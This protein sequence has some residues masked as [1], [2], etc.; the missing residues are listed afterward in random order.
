MP[1]RSSP[2]AKSGPPGNTAKIIM[3]QT[4]RLVTL[5]DDMGTLRPG[6]D[7]LQVSFLLICAEHVA[8]LADRFSGEGRSREYTKQFFNRFASHE[9]RALI[10]TGFWDLEQ[11]PLSLDAAIDALYDIRCD[12][13]HEGNYWSFSF[14]TGRYG[15]LSGEYDLIAQISLRDFRG[16]I[17]RSGI[18]AAQG[19]L[20]SGSG[21]PITSQ[22]SVRP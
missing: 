16:V 9:D 3:H 21:V 22:A 6:R 4:Q 1:R 10:R 20:G 12:V 17:V 11:R 18:R 2:R 7:A 13:V 8:K 15:M 19:A 5:A 14:R